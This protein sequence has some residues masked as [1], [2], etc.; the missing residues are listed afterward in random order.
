VHPLP[1][2]C[3]GAT[4]PRDGLP[5]GSR[6]HSRHRPSLDLRPTAAAELEELRA[7]QRAFERATADS[8]AD[9]NSKLAS[10]MAMVAN[11]NTSSSGPFPT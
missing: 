5:T 6:R 3:A 10:L 4:P 9:M 8:L 1:N 11:A 7:S 2:L